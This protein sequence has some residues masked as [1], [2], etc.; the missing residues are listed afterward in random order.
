MYHLHLQGGKSA[1][2]ESVQQVA[3]RF[4]LGSPHFLRPARKADNLTATCQSIV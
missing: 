1:K 4:L 2:Q 3:E